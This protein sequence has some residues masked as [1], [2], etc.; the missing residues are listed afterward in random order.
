MSDIS[1]PL[2]SRELFGGIFD[3]DSSGHYPGLELINFILSSPQGILPQDE[4]IKLI[5][6][7]HDFARRLIRDEELDASIRR[8]VL[9]D[10]HSEQAVSRLLKCL[11]L[12]IPNTIKT[13]SWSRTHFFPYT[14]SLVHWDARLRKSQIEI[15][16]L[17]FRG[18][19]TYAFS[20]LRKDPDAERLTRIRNGFN[21]LYPENAQSPL[22][23]LSNTLKE[24]GKIGEASFDQIES[25]SKLF[26]D[27]WEELYRYGV[28][29]ILSHIESSSVDRVRA[30][31]TWTGLWLVFMISGRSGKLLGIKFPVMILDCAGK[32]PQL[33]RAS[34]RSYK[35]KL[36]DIEKLAQEK[37]DSLGGQLSPQQLGKIRGFFGNTAVACGLGNAW[38]GRR[39]FILRLDALEALLMAGLQQNKEMEFDRFISEWLF[40]RCGL[41]IGR[42][43][44]NKAELLNNL[45]AT[46]FEEN[47]RCLSQQMQA[48]GMLK[49]YSDATRMVSVGEDR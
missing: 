35:E 27:E 49:V 39:H 44:A 13:K 25:Q 28:D 29:N 3:I 26:N 38:K 22:D 48:T 15:E 1:A 43:A 4:K 33:R 34:Q 31:V 5:R 32:H 16:R 6:V 8:E 30:L 23:L 7:A 36:T 37:A 24:K 46:I 11:E 21:N 17:Y 42:R 2:V 45:D 40:E 14:R 20:I 12:D 19:G 18:G 47:E 9:I 41:V 10:E